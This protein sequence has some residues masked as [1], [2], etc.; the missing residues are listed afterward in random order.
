MANAHA[1]QLRT[2]ASP[3]TD[4]VGL[5]CNRRRF[6]ALRLKEP[7]QDHNPGIPGAGL[8]PKL[9]GVLLSYCVVRA[10]WGQPDS[11]AVH[12][13]VLTAGIQAQVH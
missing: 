13:S 3:G 12:S 11:L 1:R 10:P 4:G 6:D 7:L 9:P 5:P 2:P 8:G